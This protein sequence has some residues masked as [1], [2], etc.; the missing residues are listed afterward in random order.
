MDFCCRCWLGNVK[1]VSIELDMWPTQQQKKKEKNVP[2][3][4]QSQL[5]F[6]TRNCV[7][8]GWAWICIEN[9]PILIWCFDFYRS[10]S[11][12]SILTFAAVSSSR[13]KR[14]V[15]VAHMHKY[16]IHIYQTR[17]NTCPSNWQFNR[18]HIN[19]KPFWCIFQ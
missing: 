12:H 18:S 4:I 14:I 10:I 11:F 16:F 2:N 6:F 5:L 19:S 17:T 3:Y 13:K 7:L 9:H 1:S 8:D 15:M